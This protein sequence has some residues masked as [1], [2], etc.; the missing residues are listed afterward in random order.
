MSI[1]STKK[2]AGSQDDGAAH[3]I[4]V[5][6]LM[7]ALMMIF[8]LLAVFYMISYD[9]DHKAQAME[10]NAF[11]SKTVSLEKALVLSKEA[12]VKKTA[13]LA[14]T[15]EEYQK[16]LAKA[17]NLEGKLSGSDALLGEKTRLLAEARTQ[18]R[19]LQ[20]TTND[21]NA[22]LVKA[23]DVKDSLAVSE[24]MLAAKS[25]LLTEATANYRALFSKSA[26]FEERLAGSEKLLAD[27]TKL[28]VEA[29][30]NYKELIGDLKGQLVGT[31]KLL[32]ET[33][34]QLKAS[35]KALK[36]KEEEKMQIF[37]NAV[38]YDD[39]IKEL[40]Q[41]LLGEFNSDFKK[42]NAELREDLT[43]RFNEPTVLF[44]VGMTEIKP[45]FKSILN[46]FFPRYISVITSDKFRKDI[47]EVRIEGHTSSF[48]SDLPPDSQEA[49]FN[50]MQLSQGRS[51]STLYYVMVLPVGK[52]NAEWLKSRL[53]AN[54]LSSSKP[55]DK[56]GYFLTDKRSDGIENTA[57]SQRV[58]FRV[59]INA[60]SKITKVIE[61]GTKK[62]ADG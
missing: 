49:Y 12:L 14:E 7:S 36:I 56:N 16:L 9:E 23:K 44:D 60:E 15:T 54:G 50:N 30:N 62:I 22:L 29:R 3:W 19:R 52:N 34:S 33:S 20:E 47:A 51:R 32:A 18:S 59:R 13:R 25:N 55:V 24:E 28:L 57:R 37:A 45:E 43:F 48:W 21:L 61:A 38:V 11:V 42:W 41:S 6:D 4:S 2:S 35:Q 58:E 1:L 17:S 40:H 8:L 46:D 10:Q 31:E 53:I 27:K 39:V 26:G 5:S